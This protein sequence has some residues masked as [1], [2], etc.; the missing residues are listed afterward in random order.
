MPDRILIRGGTVLTM[1]PGARPRLA[2]VLVEDGLIAA[3]APGLP[4]DGADVVD[5]SRCIVLPGM[6]DTHRHV[7]QTQ[8][9]GVTHDWSLKDYIRSV[10]FQAAVFYRPQ[11]MYTGN[12][13]GML[14][15]IDAGVT[16]V[17]DFSHCVNTPEHA[18]AALAGTRD[19]GIRSMFALG[20]ND[21]PVPHPHFATLEQRIE[22][23]RTLRTKE[24]PSDGGLVTMGISLSDVLVAGIERVTQ[25][26]AVSRE[27]GVRITL[28]ANAV[29]FPQPVSEVAFL[30]E[31]GL[32]G[33]DLVW[34]H[35]NQTTDE[36]LRRVADTGGAV[37]TTPETEMQMGMGH[38]AHGRFMAVGGRCTFGCDVISNNSGDLFPQV[39][40]ALQT[41]RMLRNDAELARRHGPDDI[42]PSTL[43]HLEGATVNGAEAL[44]LSSRIGTLTPGKEA[45]LIVVRG[46]APNTLPVNDPVAAIVLHAHAGNVDTVMVAGRILKRDGRLLADP[47]RRL[48]LM[49]ESHGH[50]FDAIE[51]HGG[52]I[53]QPPA[54]LPW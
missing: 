34:V 25:E 6:V 11:D 29:M 7:W 44:G 50:L 45:D 51:A 31:A 43:S 41:E 2:D 30:D 52:L 36:E 38:P 4:D 12:Y 32:L 1:E 39:R 40:L 27:L 9:R 42:G 18:E 48:A 10:R 3:V 26:V 46:D 23:A 22:H 16:T 20:L 15:A 17:L 14:E 49:D 54:P 8:L 37:S 24:L 53:P 21:V 5:A 13:L 28:H 33:P 47:A 19:S 35:M